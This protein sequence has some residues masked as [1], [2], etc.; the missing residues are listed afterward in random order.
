MILDLKKWLG[1]QRPLPP[2]EA[3]V[4]LWVADYVVPGSTVSEEEALKDDTVSSTYRVLEEVL[5]G[6]GWKLV[7]RDAEAF[8]EKASSIFNESFIWMI[9]RSA[10]VSWV[11]YILFQQ[12]WK[13]ENGWLIPYHWQEVPH[14][15]VEFVLSE[16]GV[17]KEVAVYTPSG[18]SVLNP[19]NRVIVLNSPSPKNPLGSSVYDFVKDLLDVKKKVEVSAAEHLQRFGS[20]PLI[21][22]YRVGTPQ[23]LQSEL[24]RML[25]KLKSSSVA[26]VPEGTGLEILEPRPGS[27]GTQIVLDLIRLYERRLARAIMGAILSLFE[28]EYSSRATSESHLR[29]LDTILRYHQR[30]ISR[31]VQTQVVDVVVKLN[32]PSPMD[33][34]FELNPPILEGRSVASRWIVDLTEAGY[35]SPEEDSGFVRSYFIE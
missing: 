21:G 2:E 24:L 33:V 27:A 6:G 1:R 12:F 18:R 23:N 34:R 25:T 26:V 8:L 13:E 28:S 16:S 14:S 35:L 31:I 7:G 4:R 29:L 20:P 22:R 30:T 11:R 19:P 5:V 3:S 17:V 9:C 10:W 32:S 15:S